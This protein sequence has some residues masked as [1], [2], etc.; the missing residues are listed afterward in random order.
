MSK[1]D[2]GAEKAKTPHA[3]WCST[4][5][6]FDGPFDIEGSGLVDIFSNHPID[7]ERASVTPQQAAQRQKIPG[8]HYKDHD[9]VY[10]TLKC[11]ECNLACTAEEWRQNG[12]CPQCVLTPTD[13]TKCAACG[14][15]S[16]NE[17]WRVRGG[18]S[19][20]FAMGIGHKQTL[21]PMSMTQVALDRLRP[22]LDAVGLDEETLKEE[23]EFVAE[24]IRRSRPIDMQKAMR[25]INHVIIIAKG[26]RKC[27]DCGFI[28]TDGIGHDVS[29]KCIA[30]GGY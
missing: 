17:A 21:N 18:C 8:R 25:D 28:W 15:L 2:C 10:G 12:G 22:K 3:K 4:N 20:C 27:D 13:V 19:H 7:G 29:C 16:T 6:P 5:N 23:A 30:A 26:V 9:L 14:E 1:C 11:G 24:R